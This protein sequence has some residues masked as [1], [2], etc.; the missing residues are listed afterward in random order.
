M[1]EKPEEAS[2]QKETERENSIYTL[3]D[4]ASTF[5]KHL[6]DHYAEYHEALRL[7]ERGVKKSYIARELNRSEPVISGWIDGHHFPKLERR[8]RGL[9]VFGLYP[10]TPNNPHLP[11]IALS[12]GWIIGDGHIPEDLQDIRFLREKKR[13]WRV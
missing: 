5:P 13:A 11:L 12:A 3:E 1:A 6:Q 8:I 7:W 2:T 10:L 4:F 9:R